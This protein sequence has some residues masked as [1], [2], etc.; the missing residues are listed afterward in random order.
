MIISDY[1]SSN[2]TF[3]IFLNLTYFRELEQKYK[4]IFVWLLVQMKTS[5]FAFKIIWKMV[6]NGDTGQQFT[7]VMSDQKVGGQ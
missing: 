4:N 3:C 6:H 7:N 2:K 1:L 5:K